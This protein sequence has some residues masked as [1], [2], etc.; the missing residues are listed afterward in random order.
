MKILRS[1]IIGFEGYAWRSTNVSSDKVRFQVTPLVDVK[2]EVVKN[3]K[4]LSK[5]FADSIQQIRAKHPNI[6][7]L[8]VMFIL[9]V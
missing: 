1:F 8:K 7:D 2:D 9:E 3:A 5:I 6:E 4:D